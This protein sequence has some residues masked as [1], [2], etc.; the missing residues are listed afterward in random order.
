MA[1]LHHVWDFIVRHS[2]EIA[3]AAVFALVFAVVLELLDIGSRLRAAIRYIK[4]KRSERSGRA[5][6]VKRH[7]VRIVASSAS[8]KHGCSAWLR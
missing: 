4:N 8:Y 3:V 5:Q 2:F 1:T 7:V 6:R